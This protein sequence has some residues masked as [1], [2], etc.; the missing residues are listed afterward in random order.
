MILAPAFILAVAACPSCEFTA[1][2]DSLLS[3]RECDALRVEYAGAYPYREF[4]CAPV[5][6]RTVE[7]IDG[8][9]GAKDK[10]L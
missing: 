4:E 2:S 5:Q 8:E 9:Q 6:G 7:A 1:V 10:S 3:A